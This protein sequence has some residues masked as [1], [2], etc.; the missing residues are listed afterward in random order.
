M[1]MARLRRPAIAWRGARLRGIRIGDFLRLGDCSKPTMLETSMKR[2]LL[3][4]AAIC[5]AWSGYAMAQDGRFV[6]LF[7][8]DQSTLDA[9][10]LATI[11]SAAEE[12]K[13]TGAAQLS[14][15]GNTDTSGNAEYN[16]ALS[17]RREQAVTNELVRLGVPAGAISATAVG[18]TD[19]AVPTADNVREQQNRRVEIQIAAP[20]PPPPAPAP[21]PAPVAE[22]PPPPPPAPDRD[23]F[24]FSPGLFYGYNLS[25][26]Q[27]THS[28]MI[29]LNLSLDYRAV[30]WMSVGAEQAGFYHFDTDDD[31]PGGR[32]VIG[33]DF[34][35]GDMFYAGGN[36]G[37]LYGSGIDDEFIAG[38]EIGIQWE[39]IDW[40]VAYDIPFNR[41]PGEG[42][43]NTTIGTVFRF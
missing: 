39:M 38:P 37:Y 4:S 8:F 23:R 22:T 7:P 1:T 6:V 20:P 25:D 14:V 33:P 40:K 2:A 36:I 43:I 34:F 32:T 31:G 9:S 21:E 24:S 16:Q 42:I 5:L 11:S 13:R 19:L 29:G 3:F 30:D 26:E 12:F 27:D 17:E 10:A 41:D 28:H 15:Q 35:L 18:E